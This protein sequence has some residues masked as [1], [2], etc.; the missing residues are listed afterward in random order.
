MNDFND[1]VKA[2][3]TIRDV[4]RMVGLSSARFYQLMAAGIFP[5]PVYDIISRRPHFTEEQQRQCLEVRKRNCGINGKAVCFYSRRLDATP[6]APRSRSARHHSTPRQKGEHAGLV[7]SL[8]GLGLASVTAPQVAAA[9][10][11]LYP[12]GPGQTPEPELI[13]AVFLHLKRQDR[14]DSVGT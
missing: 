10:K 5:L 13:R 8:R 9:V 11:S 2:I 3:A 6:P 7:D 4:C 12:K 14:G 1:P